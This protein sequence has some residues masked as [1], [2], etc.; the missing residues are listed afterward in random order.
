MDQEYDVIVMGTGLKECILSGLMSVN[1]KKVLHVDR[2]SYYGGESASLNLEQ[3]YEKFRGGATPP[4]EFGRTRDYCVDLCPK[5]IMACGNLVKVLLHTKVTRYLEFKSVGG[6]YVAK[7]GKIHKVPSTAAEGL[8]SDLMGIFQKR[9]FAKFAEFVDKYDMNNTKT[10]DGVDITKTTVR[11]LY[12][13]FGLDANTQQFCGHAIA[14]QLD[15]KYLDQPAKETCESMKLYANSVLR[16]GNSPYIYPVYG[17]GGL[18]EGFSRLCAIHGGTY[19]L[20]KPIAEIVYD[21]N[22]K[23]CGVKDTNGE[24]AKTKMVICDPSYVPESKVRKIG[25][26]VRCI[27]I[28]SH[29]IPNT[30]NAD[31]AQI[32]IPA[33]SV[34]GRNSDIYV[35]MISYHH[36]I[37]AT[38]KYIA[39]ISANFEGNDEKKELEPAIKLL[40]AI[41][42]TFYW[43]SD[44]FVPLENNGHDGVF[45]TASY[46]ATSHF[47]TA[48]DEV[49]A[50]Y[51]KIMGHAID[52]TIPPDLD[53]EQE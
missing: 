47:E 31:S 17:L 21:E 43:V 36:K 39:V 2:N 14:L 19:M 46:D 38:G 30:N 10:W 8:K 25:R 53:A 52:L 3:L 7:D 51:E 28:L 9:K 26:I 23:V 16:Y 33:L 42:E 40:G 18:P 1:D 34:K 27:A 45:V 11:Q 37:C 41:D 50:L 29:P 6:S 48:T 12:D 49:I 44:N 32:I 24:I 4:A 13:K 5:F 35:S 20:N 22:G 15:D